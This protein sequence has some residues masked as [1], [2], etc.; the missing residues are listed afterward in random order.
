MYE[1]L[2]RRI[3]EHLIVQIVV[4]V[5]ISGHGGSGKSTLADRLAQHFGVAKDQ[6]IRSDD[7]HAK[8]YLQAKDLFEL[9]DWATIMNILSHIR[10]SKRFQ[11]V[12]RDDKEIEHV[13]D[14]PR[15]RLVILEGIRLLRPEI[16]PYVDESVWIDCPLDVATA[17]AKK[18]NR[19]QGDSETEIAL[20]DTK[21][22][23]EAKHYFEQVAP[24]K[25]ASFIYTEY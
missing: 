14:M 18:R 12:Q 13:I 4:V 10:S 6:I 1:D 22:V 2:V 23:P 25:I 11:Y 5:A 15:P 16:L 21:W 7:L 24:D 20:W 19:E 9:H 17:R 3:E 8:N